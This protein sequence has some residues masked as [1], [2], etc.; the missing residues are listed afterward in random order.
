[1]KCSNSACAREVE[2][3]VGVRQHR[4]HARLRSCRHH[5]DAHARRAAV[6]GDHQIVGAGRDDRGQVGAASDHLRL[7]SG[8]LQHLLPVRD[9]RGLRRRRRI[10]Q[11]RGRIHR[12]IALHARAS[13]GAQELVAAGLQIDGLGGQQGGEGSQDERRVAS[14]V[15]LLSGRAME[16]RHLRPG[17]TGCQ[18]VRRR[19]YYGV[20][21]G[22]HGRRA[23]RRVPPCPG[24][25]QGCRSAATGRRAAAAARSRACG[26]PAHAQP[27]DRIVGR[28]RRPEIRQIPRPAAWCGTSNATSERRRSSVSRI[29]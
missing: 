14:M 25:D 20:F 26:R 12:R 4:Q 27:F 9:D 3:L 17:P 6:V 18:A 22:I 29:P 2:R 21:M 8:V 10:E 19:E 7:V 1:M 5:L 28:R 24:F 16:P 23:R 13:P 11:D 15:A